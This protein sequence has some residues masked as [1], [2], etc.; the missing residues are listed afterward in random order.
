MEPFFGK[1]ILEDLP[2]ILATTVKFL[3][4]FPVH[5][6]TRNRMERYGYW[7]RLQEMQNVRLLPPQKYVNF[8]ALERKALFVAADGGSIQ[9]ETCYMGVPCL[10]FRSR[11]ER[12]DGIG[13]TA[14]LADFDTAKVKSFL[15]SHKEFVDTDA[16][17]DDVFPSKMIIDEILKW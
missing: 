2:D 12:Y 11:T 9:E 8:V 15:E 6:P 3:V 10:I 14:M 16:K 17:Y 13:K 1:V 5:D 7:T 4:V